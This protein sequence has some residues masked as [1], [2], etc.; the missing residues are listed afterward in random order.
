M[1][2]V[3]PWSLSLPLPSSSS[4]SSGEMS[5][6]CADCHWQCN[7]VIGAVSRLKMRQQYNIGDQSCASYFSDAA[8]MALLAPC[9]LCQ[10]LNEIDLRDFSTA[11]VAVMSVNQ[12]LLLR[13]G[14]YAIIAAPTGQV[15]A[16]VPYLSPSNVYYNS[17]PIQ[18]PGGGARIQPCSA[19]DGFNT[20]LPPTQQRF[21][22]DYRQA[23][24]PEGSV[25]YGDRAN[26]HSNTGPGYGGGAAV[27]PRGD[28]PPPVLN[29][30]VLIDVAHV[31]VSVF[32]GDH[33]PGG[34]GGWLGSSVPY[35]QYC[36]PGPLSAAGAA[37]DDRDGHRVDNLSPFTSAS[38]RPPGPPLPSS[39]STMD[40]SEQ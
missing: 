40:P 37:A 39:E 20:N 19:G 27:T 14:R 12:P 7:D 22:E 1:T 15:G 36:I 17:F 4:L 29:V 25:G 33:G 24:F 10:E 26:V 9:L 8:W 5:T 35:H 13:D 32:G 11:Q 18:Q 34:S 16:S 28:I 30:P 21:E 3:M 31:P 23:G 2:L 6:N 38:S